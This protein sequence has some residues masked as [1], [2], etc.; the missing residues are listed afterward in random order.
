M[1]GPS[2]LTGILAAVM[3][4]TAIYCV[5]RLIISRASHR[6]AERDVDLVHAVMGV[7]M[8]GMLVARL[9]PLPNAAWAVMFS[10]ATAWFG[11]RISR[12]HRSGWAETRATGHAHG[13]HVPH[14][15]M[16]GAMVYML[17]AVAAVKSGSAAGRMSMGGA[18]AHFPLLALVLALFMFGYV[19]WQADRLPA[20]AR[21]GSG[22]APVP[23]LTG[24]AS[25]GALAQAAGLPD[26]PLPDVSGAPST[27]EAA[28][29]AGLSPARS[30][31]AVG[32]CRRG[33]PRA[34]RSRWASRWA[35][36]SS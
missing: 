24:T 23:A 25:G 12:A 4:A 13:H 27:L 3:I 17:L 22:L 1:A 20:L 11:W 10:G 2:W 29:A 19:M 30:H 15:V 35:T 9:N 36:C 18:G 31:Q 8:A 21:A 16:C 6:P 28:A 5:S 34:A 33:S 26:V 14:L 32:R 7:A